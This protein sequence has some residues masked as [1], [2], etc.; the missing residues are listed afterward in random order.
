MVHSLSYPLALLSGVLLAV[1]FPRFGYPPFGWIALTPLLV[2]L[3]PASRPIAARRAFALG[4][5]AGIVYFAGTVYWTG[6]TV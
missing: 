4:L 2:A 3:A 1:S 5:V 6:A